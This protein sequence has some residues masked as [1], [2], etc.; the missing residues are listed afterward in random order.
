MNT[1]RMRPVLATLLLALLAAWLLR[2]LQLPLPW[3]VGPLLATAGGRLAG[4]SLQGPRWGRAAGQWAIG[5]ALGLYFTPEVVRLLGGLLPYLLPAALFAFVLAG[6]GALLLQRWSGLDHGSAFFA[7]MPGGASEMANLAERHGVRVDMVAAAHSLRML[8]VVT[9][10]PALFT[11]SGVHGA[12][13]YHA[14]G[15]TL[16]Y[17]GLL[18]LGALGLA[19]GWVWSRL[20]QPNP[21]MIGPLLVT[22]LL[23][24][25]GIELSA[26]PPWASP[27]AQLLIGCSLGS[28]FSPG[29]FRVAPRFLA[30][31]AASSGVLML[32]AAAFG[33]ALAWLAGLNPATVMLGTTPGGIAEMCL[34]AHALQLGVPVVTAF[35]VC[36]M[37]C[38]VL[39]TDP[40]YR[41]LAVR[42]ARR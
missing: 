35:Q 38:V 32:A 22:V 23:T 26:L 39:L 30:A 15:R 1:D 2:A 21:W 14:A 17:P 11:L 29:F 19:A 7:S 20:R 5:S 42:L 4:L 41:Y 3:L 16:H 40:L 28:R 10:I 25:S 24:A 34:T 33:G 18:L 9:L 12:D 27:L 8:L 36:R 31:V 13:L 37:L 6:L